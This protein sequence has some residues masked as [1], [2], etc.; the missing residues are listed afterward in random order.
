MEA[1]RYEVQKKFLLVHTAT[2]ILPLIPV[3]VLYWA[4]SQ[5]N[6]SSLELVDQGLR[7]GGP[8]AAYYVLYRSSRAGAIGLQ[9][10][11]RMDLL[12]DEEVA[13]LLSSFD[14][15]AFRTRFELEESY[16]ASRRR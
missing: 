14:S 3:V 15:A 10:R 2:L 4:F 5:A 7:L 9:A 1:D 6:F 8:I 16:V 12:S 13:N 11:E